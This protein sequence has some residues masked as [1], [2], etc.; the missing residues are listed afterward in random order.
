MVV[1]NRKLPIIEPEEPEPVDE[2]GDNTPEEPILPP[3]G[4]SGPLP[5]PAPPPPRE[6]PE[7]PPQRVPVWT[8]PTLI[9]PAQPQPKSWWRKWFGQ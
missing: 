4:P 8:Q 5:A 6:P 1:L 7:E 9:Q 3:A 2:P